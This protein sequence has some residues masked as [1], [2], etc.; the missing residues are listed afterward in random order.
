MEEKKEII[1]TLCHFIE[2]VLI[3][4]NI[5][6]ALEVVSEDVLGVGM[7][8]QGMVS[9]KEDVRKIL[10]LQK[11]IKDAIYSV[12]YKKIDSRFYPPYFGSICI[13]FELSC[14]ANKEITKSEYLQFASVRK[15]ENKWLLCSLQ[16][17]PIKS[18]ITQKNIE[19]Y[20][21]VFAEE[22]L[23]QLKQN[24]QKDAI[25]FMNGCISGGIIA[26]YIEENTHP[27]YFINES[28]LEY[29]GY[30]KQEFVEQYSKD[31][32]QIIH[33]ADT[34]Y[35]SKKVKD[36]IL[37]GRDYEAKFRVRKKDGQYLYMLE[38]VRKS[39]DEHGKPILMGVFID[40]TEMVILQNTLEEQTS[41]L[42][43]QKEE[44]EAQTLTL[45]VQNEML[46]SRNKELEQKTEALLISEERFRI[47]LEK[48]SNIIFDYNFINGHVI[49]S[50]ASEI[51]PKDPEKCHLVNISYFLE[52]EIL[53]EYKEEYVQMF[54]RIKQGK[55]Q[56]HCIIKIKLESG[57]VQW[58]QVSVTGILDSNGN[59][60]RAIGIIEDITRQKEAEIAYTREEQYRKA[61]LSDAMASYI[62]NFT[63]GIFES[64][65]VE[66]SCCVTT[67][68]GED[69]DSFV[70]KVAWAR[71]DV[72]E[73][74]EFLTTF[75]RANVLDRFANGETEFDLEYMSIVT[76]GSNRWMRTTMH[77][78]L[79]ATTNEIKGFMYV[80]DIDKRKKKELELTHKSERD[81]MTGVYNKVITISKIEEKLK[82]FDGIKTGVF[83]MIDVDDFKHINDTYGHPFGDKVLISLAKIISESFREDD[84]IG[85]LGGD[86]FCVFFC[87]MPSMKRIKRAVLGLY[88]RIYQELKSEDGKVHFSC[89]IGIAM[90]NGCQKNFE[91][92]Y[93]E[94]DEA[95]YIAKK[96]GRNQFVFFKE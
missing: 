27:L 3:E 5:E 46:E 11:P 32:M 38:Q 58:K 71:L 85:R 59:T 94:A 18:S 87:G 70:K 16:A 36:N 35:V 24:I 86:E 39:Q 19:S 25:E 20:P 64:C 34:A 4:N 51:L 79:D 33:P 2:S 63:K 1:L 78:I 29:L 48:T 30:T 53:E 28:M 50:G 21:I 14:E 96:Q 76:D 67:L 81:S 7:G 69:Y 9:C 74:I 65:K 82:M 84:I 95:L 26:T 42:E 89:S 92:I 8:E 75:S 43:A 62:I 22:I 37:S 83:M 47:A 55:I 68:P 80:I 31:V 49:H 90:C 45:E 52:G 73:R 44:L 57:I 56:D 40:I 6:K 54:E 61:I 77:L 23:A 13:I 15:E 12:E 17:Q 72:E 91:K 10:L 41:E 93:K 60:V 88:H 66:D